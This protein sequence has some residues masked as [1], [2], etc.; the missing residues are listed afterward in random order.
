MVPDFMDQN[1]GHKVGQGLLAGF[2]P[3]VEYRPTV[4]ENHV[5]FTGR[6]AACARTSTGNRSQAAMARRSRS[7]RLCAVAL[8]QSGDE[9]MRDPVWQCRVLAVFHPDDWQMTGRWL[10]TRLRGLST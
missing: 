10:V 7:S 8:V 1:V 4:E 5:S 2:R 9:D 6:I 3:V